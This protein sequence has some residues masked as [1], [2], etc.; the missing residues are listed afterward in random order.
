MAAYLVTLCDITDWS[1]DLKRYIEISAAL[2]AEH[3]GSYLT[4]GAADTVYEGEYMKNK[5]LITARFPSMDALKGFRESEH[6][7]QNV[8][9]LRDGTGIYD[10]GAWEERT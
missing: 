2:L 10:M 4:R 5:L 9:P 6:Y 8:K 3:G 7:A 1:D